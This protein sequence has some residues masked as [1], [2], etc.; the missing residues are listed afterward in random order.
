MP[1]P[2]DKQFICKGCGRPID[3]AAAIIGHSDTCPFWG[4]IEHARIDRNSLHELL[5]CP[6]PP[7]VDPEK[8]HTLRAKA[9]D[10]ANA[11]LAMTPF[12]QDQQEALRN[13]HDALVIATLTLEPEVMP[14]PPPPPSPKRLRRKAS[15]KP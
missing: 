12:C 2:N 6:A 15:R 14:P 1:T 11:I 3:K 13:L 5:R 8:Y 10:F 4:N 7:D 9:Y